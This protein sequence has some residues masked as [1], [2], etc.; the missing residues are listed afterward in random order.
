VPAWQMVSGGGRLKS[1]TKT[2]YA[3]GEW[4]LVTNH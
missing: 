1:E 4:A 2:K 3:D